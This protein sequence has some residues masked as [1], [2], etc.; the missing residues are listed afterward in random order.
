MEEVT[1]SEE[2]LQRVN[3]LPRINFH[4]FNELVANGSVEAFCK[5]KAPKTIFFDE[6]DGFFYYVNPFYKELWKCGQWKEE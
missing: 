5:F 2:T 1:I 3:T 6:A 4:A